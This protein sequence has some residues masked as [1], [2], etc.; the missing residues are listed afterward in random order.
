MTSVEVLSLDVCSERDNQLKVDKWKGI[1]GWKLS[2]S[3]EEK[4]DSKEM[5]K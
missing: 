1:K 4:Q 3:D 5:S 2:D